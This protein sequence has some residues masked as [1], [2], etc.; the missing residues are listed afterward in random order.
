MLTPSPRAAPRPG[1]TV[2]R[3]RQGISPPLCLLEPWQLGNG[4]GGGFF[5]FLLISSLLSHVLEE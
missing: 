4:G 2:K 5:F 3:E 1:A